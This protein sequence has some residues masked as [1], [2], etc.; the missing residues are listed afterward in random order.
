[1]AATLA[2]ANRR[3]GGPPVGATGLG[4][5]N[6]A[7]HL[8]LDAAVRLT[9]SGVAIERIEAKSALEVGVADLALDAG[10]LLGVSESVR[11][12][13]RLALIRGEEVLAEAVHPVEVLPRQEWGGASM[14]EAQGSNFVLDG[15]PGTGKS[16]TI[17]NI[18]AHNIALG[19]KVLFVAGRWRR[20]VWCTG[21]SRSRGSGRSV[22]SFTRTRPTRPTYSP[23]SAAP[24]IRARASCPT[25]GGVRR[26]GSSACAM[27]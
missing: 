14:Q 8:D 13:V 16:Q 5:W 6:G 27:S 17:A 25:S 20:S 3:P 24:G 19:R 26:R 11:G 10:F 23:S 22:S 9:P 2:H 1:M 18:I 15:P 21:A 7:D 4:T 12:T